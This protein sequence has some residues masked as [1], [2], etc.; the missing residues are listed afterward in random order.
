VARR[1][2]ERW[3][4]EVYHNPPGT[5]ASGIHGTPEQVRERLEDLVAAG[6]NHLLL[7][8]ISRYAEQLEAVA[9]VAGFK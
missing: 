4:T 3:F 1:E 6:A 9:E 8:P 5:D 2:V 7:N